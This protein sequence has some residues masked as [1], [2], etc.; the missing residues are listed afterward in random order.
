MCKNK[1]LDVIT[2]A[3]GVK[4]CVTT[5]P[6]NPERPYGIYTFMEDDQTDDGSAENIFFTKEEATAC[7]NWLA[8]NEVFP[9]TLS[10]V[11]SDLYLV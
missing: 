4:Y 11:L 1:E 8:D 7:C 2:S 3:N 5:E 6:L 10:E 9:V